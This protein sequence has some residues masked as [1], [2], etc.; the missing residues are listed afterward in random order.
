MR[1]FNPGI[2]RRQR[3]LLIASSQ[4]LLKTVRREYPWEETSEGSKDEIPVEKE[5]VE[6]EGSLK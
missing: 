3:P 5:A 4:F 2:D 6:R 1:E